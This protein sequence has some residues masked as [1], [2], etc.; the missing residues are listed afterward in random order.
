MYR[1]RP[2]SWRRPSEAGRCA[3]ADPQRRRR[4]LSDHSDRQ[5]RAGAETDRGALDGRPA[6][7]ESALGDDHDVAGDPDAVALD[8]G[9][10]R[11]GPSD[12][13][14]L[15]DGQLADAGALGDVREQ[16][17]HRGAG[18]R[19]LERPGVAQEE[20]P[21]PPGAVLR[22]DGGDVD[23]DR[24]HVVEE[25]GQER[26]VGAGACERGRVPHRRHDVRH[27]GRDE[28]R[29]PRRVRVGRAQPDGSEDARR[30]ELGA[31]DRRVL[32]HRGAGVRRRRA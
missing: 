20:A 14:A 17:P 26:L 28:L 6:T 3:A 19:V 16:R 2:W 5:P 24:A 4:G 13:G 32:Q 9:V 29:R 12:L 30:I 25:R 21:R 1:G 31:E 15:P 27:A 11:A 8:R 10:Q 7:E 23:A 18:R 22:V